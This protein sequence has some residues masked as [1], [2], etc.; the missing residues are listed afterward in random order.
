MSA[1]V[2]DRAAD[3]R[4]REVRIPMDDGV[5]LSATVYLPARGEDGEPQPCILEAL[6][7][8]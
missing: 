4:C 7:Y 3:P 1:A 6:P 8:R 2:H 5:E